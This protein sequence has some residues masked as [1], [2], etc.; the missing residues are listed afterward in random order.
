ML[1][2]LNSN[3]TYLSELRDIS[4]KATRQTFELVHSDA[5]KGLSKL[6]AKIEAMI[7][8]IV[9]DNEKIKTNYELLMR[10]PGIRYPTAIYLICCASNFAC[11]CSGKQLVCYAG[12]QQRNK[13]QRT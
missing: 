8:K 11:G 1:S 3:K 6:I 13:H 5:I 9:M 10:V 12:A 2:Q 7:K 4:D